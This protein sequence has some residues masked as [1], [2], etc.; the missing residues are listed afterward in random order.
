VAVNGIFILFE[1]EGALGD[2]IRAIQRRWDPKLANL[3]PPHVT[4]IGS[5]GAGPIR[6]DVPAAQLRSV[7]APIVA[8]AAP[9]TLRFG[10][11]HRFVDRDII[12]L[13]L[14]P[15]GPL[16][17]LHESLKLSGLPMDLARYPF[18]PHCT[19]SLFPQLTR[20]AIQA[21]MA[22][23][24]EEPFQLDRLRVYHTRDPQPA[25]RLLD[26][27]LGTPSV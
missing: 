3:Q 17:A 26:L 15:H 7:L 5:S 14:D 18:T 10:A 23:R 9:L 27:T 25:K 13:P 16:R 24:E 8:H 22:V 21:L 2:R 11:P 20:E 4:L 1:I 12:S 6:P 19:L